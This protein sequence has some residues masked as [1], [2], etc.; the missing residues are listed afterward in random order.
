M[1]D[2]LRLFL[3]KLCKPRF[4]ILGVIA[5]ALIAGGILLYMEWDARRPM[6][7]TIPEPVTSSVQSGDDPALASPTDLPARTSIVPARE[8]TPKPS[9]EPT[10]EALKAPSSGASTTDKPLSLKED[11]VAMLLFSG[12]KI[13]VKRGVDEMTLDKHV[14]W[15][16]TSAAPGDIGVCVL[17]GH[18]DRELKH[19]K[20]VKIGS[21]LT[22][23]TLDGDFTYTVYAM[24]IIDKDTPAQ[25]P[26][27]TS[28]ELMILTCYPFYFSGSAPQ[29]IVISARR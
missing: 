23:R 18:R 2:K 24:D 19:M 1:I 4:L 13:A 6:D 11:E 27:T 22:L 3:Q 14:G 26:A 5:A 29:Q 28:S 20:N 25:I 21:E 12:K 17:M 15:M 8:G 16:E 10:P 7:F 9:A